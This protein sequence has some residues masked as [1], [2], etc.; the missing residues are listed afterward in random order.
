MD[1]TFKIGD[2]VRFKSGSPDLTV[3]S[4]G[5]QSVS[6]ACYDEE[7]V[8]KGIA[9]NYNGTYFH[10][11]LE[12]VAGVNTEAKANRSKSKKKAATVIKGDKED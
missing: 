3:L 8:A 5:P 11:D 4:I 9:I 1:H 10:G 7:A 2:V 6:V 12:L